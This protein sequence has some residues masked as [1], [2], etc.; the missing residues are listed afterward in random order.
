MHYLCD[1]MDKLCTTIG[2]VLGWLGTAPT[3]PLFFAQ[4]DMTGVIRTGRRPL[5]E[6][7]LVTAGE[8][9]FTVGERRRHLA[10]GDLALINAHFDNNGDLRDPIDRY[11]CVSFSVAGVSALDDL[12]KAPLFEVARIG[13]RLLAQ[14]LYQRVAALH[15]APR[16]PVRAFRLKAAVLEL[17][18]VLSEQVT[19]HGSPGGSAVSRALAFINEHHADPD[20]TL[21]RI[22]EA[23]HVSPAHLCRVVTGQTGLSPMHYVEHLRTSRAADLLQRTD[24]PVKRIADMVG[25]RDQLYFSRVFRKRLGVAPSRYRAQGSR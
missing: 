12:G 9:E 25:Y 10:A 24:L 7:L 15:I 11:A 14:G 1:H 16:S 8:F 21:G 18:S 3:V 2:R 6:L 13:D 23:A 20:L 22:A 19:H 5:V 4:A 17:L